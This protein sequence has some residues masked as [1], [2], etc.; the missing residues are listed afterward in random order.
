MTTIGT[1]ALPNFSV[2]TRNA[3]L[4][5]C[6]RVMSRVSL[7]SAVSST[8]L[9]VDNIPSE[10]RH[11]I[12]CGRSPSGFD[13]WSSRTRI[14]CVRN[15]CTVVTGMITIRLGSIP[16][17]ITICFVIAL[18]LS[19]YNTPASGLASR[20]FLT[21]PMRKNVLP[22]ALSPAIAVIL[23][24][25]RPPFRLPDRSALKMYEPVS[26]KLSTSPAS[27]PSSTIAAYS[28]PA[29]LIASCKKLFIRASSIN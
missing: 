1:F 11:N 24:D 13:R 29:A 17:S 25:G 10:S 2:R 5:T 3:A 28:F 22:V 16:R 23:F 20:K 21:I 19:K 12:I 15:S 26:I 14:A 27:T 9:V 4:R 8:S 6:A 18:S 7:P